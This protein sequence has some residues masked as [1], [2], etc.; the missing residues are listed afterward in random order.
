MILTGALCDDI[1]VIVLFS[2][3]VSANQGNS[4]D[5]ATFANIPVSIIFGVF[6]GII[7]GF[8]IYFVFETAFRR[9]HKIRGSIKVIILL[10]VSFLLVV[11]LHAKR[12]K[13]TR[14][15]SKTRLK[16][17]HKVKNPDA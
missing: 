9:N 1:F 3:F 12:Q 16:N 8:G 14:K 4:V 10:A 6:L 7:F 17:L 15:M 2:V 13:F 11:A 5:I